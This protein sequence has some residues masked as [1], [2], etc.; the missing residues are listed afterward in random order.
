VRYNTWDFKNVNNADELW[1]I[2]GSQNFPGGQTSTF[3]LEYYGNTVTAFC[4][5]RIINHRG[6]WGIFHNNLVSGSSNPGIHMSQYDGGCNGVVDPSWPPPNAEINNTYVFNNSVNGTNT[7][8]NAPVSA[9]VNNTCPATKDLTF[10]NPNV[11][12]CTNTRA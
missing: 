10:W 1:D 2:H 3:I 4:G 8:A 12:G 9:L 11:T 7:S 6:S 5:F